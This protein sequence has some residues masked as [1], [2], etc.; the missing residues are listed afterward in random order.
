MSYITPF[1]IKKEIV[2]FL[3]NQ[4]LISVGTRGVTTQQDTGTFSAAATHTLA[5]SPT[6]LK[7]I[8]SIVVDGST[9][10]YGLDYTVD[11]AT[12]VITFTV[13]QTG[14]YTIDYDT[15]TTDKVFPDYPQGDLKISDFPRIA[16]D[17]ISATTTELE[18]GAASNFTDYNISIIAYDS[19]QD[20]VEAL[21]AAIR[22]ALISNKKTFYY[23][24][25]IKPTGMGPR[26]IPGFGKNKI[27][28]R[29]QDFQI[30]FVYED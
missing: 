7:N 11:D 24:P 12:G 2:Y 13:A 14:A 27:F 23:F 16:F 15:G 22:A 4:D 21:I 6:L 19:D 28:Q 26:I 8:R 25:F 20:N 18:L 10:D 9:L 17:I 1:N 30:R 5:T 29:N 3:R